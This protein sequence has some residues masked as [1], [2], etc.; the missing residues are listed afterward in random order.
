MSFFSPNIDA[1]GRRMRAALG[2]LLLAG[3]AA[4]W[5]AG[6]PFLLNLALLSGGLF[7]LF[8]ASRGWCVARACG[9]KTSV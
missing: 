6:L 2:L 9:I 3:S 8:E 7:A 4:G 5:W 1:T